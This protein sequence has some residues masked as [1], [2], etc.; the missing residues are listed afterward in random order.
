MR[1]TEVL[2]LA[3]LVSAVRFDQYDPYAQYDGILNRMR[4]D[5]NEIDVIGLNSFMR[6]TSA[7]LDVMNAKLDLLMVI[8][9]EEAEE[10][11]MQQHHDEFSN[12][13]RNENIPTLDL[14]PQLWELL[15]E[16]MHM[17]QSNNSS[18]AVAK[19]ESVS[20][21]A[22]RPTEHSPTTTPYWSTVIP[23]YL[24]GYDNRP[25]LSSSNEFEFDVGMRANSTTG[26][27]GMTLRV[28]P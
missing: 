15:H 7:M 13:H 23:P 26:N 17:H 20:S 27:S 16:F 11:R 8:H 3:T 2:A 28:S 10:K 14:R 9:Q 6:E 4:K 19:A 21:S 5:E 12:K 1:L 24:S 18:P 25:S 22:L